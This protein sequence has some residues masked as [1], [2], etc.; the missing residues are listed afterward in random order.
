M[1]KVL[2]A[3]GVQ[4]TRPPVR[5]LPTR[6]LTP[7]NPPRPAFPTG[8]PLPRPV[9]RVKHFHTEKADANCLASAFMLVG[10]QE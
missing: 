5:A 10:H 1:N 9:L 3:L 7:A 6:A 2:V 8:G 4:M